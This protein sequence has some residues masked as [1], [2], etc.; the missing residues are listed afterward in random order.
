VGLAARFTR[1]ALLDLR[2][3]HEHIRAENPAA[4]ERVRLSILSTVGMLRDFPYLGRSGRRRGTREKT[5]TKLPYLILYRVDAEEVI[6]LRIYHGARNI[7]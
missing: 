3:I 1:T 4:A 6:I 7:R 5:V 2:R